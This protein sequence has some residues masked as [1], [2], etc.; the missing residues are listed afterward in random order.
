MK[1]FLHEF[2]EFTPT[3]AGKMGQY[4]TAKT[5]WREDGTDGTHR[6]YGLDEGEMGVIGRLTMTYEA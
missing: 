1:S 4:F 5:P 3:G 6:T 2:H